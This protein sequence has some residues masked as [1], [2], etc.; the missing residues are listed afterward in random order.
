MIYH[1]ISSPRNL[2]T[3]MMYSFY[4]RGDTKVVDEPFY[5]YYLSKTGKQHPGHQEITSNMSTD[6]EEVKAALALERDEPHL[7]IKD[8]AHHLIEMDLSFMETHV[9]IFLIRNP[10]QL[11]ASFAQVIPNPTMADIG[12]KRQYEIFQSVKSSGR[13]AFVVDSGDL[14]ENIES[15]VKKLCAQLDLDYRERMISWPKGAIEADGPWAQY[16]YKNIHEST[17]FKKQSSSNRPLPKACQE[18]YEQSKLYYD[19]LSNYALK[20]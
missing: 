13:K 3:A 16:W 12:L 9:P 15:Y 19:E 8:M 18:L 4:H 14:L 17:G 11:I 7:F 6:P 20:V 1:L 5:G 2:S 10:H